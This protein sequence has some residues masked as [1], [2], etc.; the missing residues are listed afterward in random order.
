M[1]QY[2][3]DYWVGVLTAGTLGFCSAYWIFPKLLA[4]PVVISLFSEEL[5][6]IWGILIVGIFLV[7]GAFFWPCV[8]I[9]AITIGSKLR[10]KMVFFSF[11][12]NIVILKI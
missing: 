11:A 10:T 6:P 12:D 9:L 3:K 7:L 8:K 4:T 5:F 1:G 2:L